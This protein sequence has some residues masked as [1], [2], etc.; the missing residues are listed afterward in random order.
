MFDFKAFTADTTCKKRTKRRS[1]VF[2]RFPESPEWFAPEIDVEEIVRRYGS[3]EW[4]AGVLTNEIHGHLGI[5]AV[6]GVKMGIYALELLD[7]G[8]DDISVTS[9]A[10]SQPPLSCMNDGL[11]ISTGA[12]VGHGLFHVACNPNP[13]PEATFHFWN[14]SVTLQLLPEYAAR[15]RENVL[16]GVRLYGNHTETYWEYIRRL[17]IRYWLEFDRRFLFQ[18][19]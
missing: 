3:D 4:R 15:I 17:A 13:H 10:G 9:Y 16:E 7:T 19:S 11:Q 18:Q 1:H 6:I 8:I 12:T 5:Y 2:D 14:R